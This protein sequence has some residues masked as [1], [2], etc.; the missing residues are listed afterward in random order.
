MNTKTVHIK[1]P[2]QDLL[3]FVRKLQEEKE[4]TKKEL[5]ALKDKYFPKK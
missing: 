5:V 4:A 2:S 1:K 3:A